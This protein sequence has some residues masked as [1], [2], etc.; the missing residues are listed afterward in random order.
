[1]VSLQAGPLDGNG[2]AAPSAT[3]VEGE[4]GAAAP[5]AVLSK[6][7]FKDALLELEATVR[8]TRDASSAAVLQLWQVAEKRLG[9]E[10][11]IEDPALRGLFG[12]HVVAVE[13]LC[14]R[15]RAQAEVTFAAVEMWSQPQL[16]LAAAGMRLLSDSEAGD[17]SAL[18]QAVTTD[19]ADA[20]TGT[21]KAMGRLS[22]RIQSEVFD[23]IDARLQRHAEIREDVRERQRWGGFAVAARRDVAWLR[24]E[25]PGSSGLLA[26]SLRSAGPLEEAEVRLRE[27]SSKVAD[28]D[29]RLLTSLTELREESVSSVRRPWAALVQIQSEF[30]MAQQA[31][32]TSLL[33]AF[34]EFAP[35]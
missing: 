8:K 7:A 23:E 11:D 29:S 27:A 10:V 30:F 32:W 24:K 28:L 17:G 34:G 14:S 18:G 12:L 5:I 13:E 19:L 33:D 3:S 15:V 22:S 20:D 4:R 21:A 9:V 2:N 6:L 31:I 25:S 26:L 1:M 16:V 35:A